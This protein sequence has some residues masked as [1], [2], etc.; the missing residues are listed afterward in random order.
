MTLKEEKNELSQDEVLWI[1]SVYEQTNGEGKANFRELLV[2]LWDDLSDDFHPTNVNSNFYVSDTRNERYQ[3][4]TLM[5]VFLVDPDN[6]LIKDTDAVIK[7]VRRLL[8]ENPQLEEVS[9]ARIAESLSIQEERV[10]KIFDYMRDLGNFW[11]GAS[12]E[13]DVE[14]HSKIR[15][16]NRVSQLF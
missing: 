7:E 9:S 1:E 8:V 2:E 3:E 16:Y 13:K 14:G 6:Q 4:L 5:G 11:S 10:R 12:S 15:C